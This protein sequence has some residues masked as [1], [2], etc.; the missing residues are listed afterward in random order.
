MGV[1]VEDTY[2][3]LITRRVDAAFVSIRSALLGA[4]YYLVP[5][6]MNWRHINRYSL[7]CLR[8]KVCTNY[9][10][11]TIHRVQQRF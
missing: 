7:K 1:R 2:P 9:C 8:D 11:L 3:T 4:Q 6:G 10:I 5:I